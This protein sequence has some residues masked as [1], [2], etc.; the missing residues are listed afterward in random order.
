[1]VD[2]IVDDWIKIN[3]VVLGYKRVGEETKHY[4]VIL[5]KMGSRFCDIS[6]C[7]CAMLGYELS[8]MRKMPMVQQ[9]FLGS[10]A[11][12]SWKWDH[13]VQS[14][15]TIIID[16]YWSSIL[17]IGWLNRHRS[18]R[19]CWFPRPESSECGL[20]APGKALCAWGA[21]LS[22]PTSTLKKVSRMVI[23]TNRNIGIRY[24]LA[25]RSEP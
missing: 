16:I 19:S 14:I 18:T 7:S 13:H 17:Q 3:H 6:F 21:H 9:H 20:Q 15:L 10:H 24:T 1:M 2:L 4:L 12:V 23:H 8:E 5:R 22:Q 25:T 11:I